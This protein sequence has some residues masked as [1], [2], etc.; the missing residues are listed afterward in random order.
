MINRKSF[1]VVVV[2]WLV[3]LLT[4]DSTTDVRSKCLEERTEE[5][6]SGVGTS[7]GVWGQNAE[8]RKWGW[9]GAWW[10]A[11]ERVGML[12]RQGHP[13]WGDAGNHSMVVLSGK[14]AAWVVGSS[15]VVCCSL[16]NAKIQ[17]YLFASHI[18]MYTGICQMQR[19]RARVRKKEQQ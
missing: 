16:K 15:W 5:D 19:T 9:R 6:N 18:K 13:V 8:L 17:G 4:V 7:A 1:D 2:G 10:G 11:G 3:A 14:V 12:W